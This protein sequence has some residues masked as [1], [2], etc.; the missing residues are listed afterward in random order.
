MSEIKI[1]TNGERKTTQTSDGRLSIRVP[2]QIGRRSGRN[3]IKAPSGEVIG[4]P[5][6]SEPTVFQLSLAR[7][8]RWARMFE[9]GEV[10]SLKEIAERECVDKSYV[11]RLINLTTLAPSI[12][13]AILDDRLPSDLTILELA[14]NP[15]ALWEE[16]CDKFTG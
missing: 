1:K 14:V 15:P 13:E 5:W 6:N 4:T 9:T 3:Q 12:V 10:D 8:H 7:G 16:Q 11:S 2:I